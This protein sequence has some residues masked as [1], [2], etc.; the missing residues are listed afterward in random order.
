MEFSLSNRLQAVADLVCGDYLI[1]VGTDHAM[2]PIY[3]VKNKIVKNAIASDINKAPLTKA[4]INI[5]I[6]H[7]DGSIK[8]VLTPGL[9]GLEKHPVT[10]I[11]IAGLG[12]LN[13][14]EILE[15]A[16]FVK[17]QNIH[18]ILQPMQHIAELRKYLYDNGYEIEKEVFASEES[19]IYQIMSV[20][21]SGKFEEY[22]DK[23]LVLGKYSIE[24][25]KQNPEL[26]NMFCDKFIYY[27]NDKIK[28]LKIGGKDTKL[29]EKLLSEL[30]NEK[31]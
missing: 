8:T 10:D 15:E 11:S 23:E 13:I 20:T 6:N 12:G 17:R 26:F 28:G 9:K 14:I 16:D 31:V 2:L 24:N 22:C 19:K 3:L 1:D 30:M 4:E 7:L 5:K 18:L 29:D 25:K 21:Y 27:Y